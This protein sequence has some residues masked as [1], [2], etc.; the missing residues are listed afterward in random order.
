MK[1]ILWGGLVATLILI[2]LIIAGPAGSPQKATT[3]SPQSAE[4]LPKCP[5][6]INLPQSLGGGT[7][8]VRS[9]AIATKTAVSAAAK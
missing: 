3:N 6:Q 2:S 5:S 7:I 4:S 9:C 1:L 8:P